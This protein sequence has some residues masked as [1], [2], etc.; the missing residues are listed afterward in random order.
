MK[1]NFFDYLDF[2]VQIAPA[3]ENE[4]AMRTELA[5]FGNAPG[6]N[7]DFKD[8]ATEQKLEI[9]LGMKEGLRKVDEA[10]G[11][12]RHTTSRAGELARCRA[13]LSYYNGDRLKRA[14]AAQAGIDGNVGVE[15]CIRSG[16]LVSDGQTLEKDWYSWVGSNHRPPVPQ[17]GA[18][19]N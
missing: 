9:G 12:G 3:L 4:K 2:A 10:D 19:T 11:L 18:L 17:T 1:R 7:F 13:T 16:A 5:V 15:R 6:K 14:I 8:L